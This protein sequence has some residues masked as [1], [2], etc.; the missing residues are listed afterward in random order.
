MEKKKVSVEIVLKYDH[1]KTSRIMEITTNEPEPM[2]AEVKLIKTG[3][4]VNQKQVDDLK[5]LL[6]SRIL[7]SVYLA[8]TVVWKLEKRQYTPDSMTLK[9]VYDLIYKFTEQ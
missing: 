9:Q 8:S 4:Y 6:G 1:T 7:N 3:F 2:D 5:I